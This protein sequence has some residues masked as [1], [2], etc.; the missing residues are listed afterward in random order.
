MIYNNGVHD[1]ITDPAFRAERQLILKQGEPMLFGENNDKGL[2]VLKGKLT[3][4]TPG[5]DDFTPGDILI[6]D[7]TE[8]D[9]LLHLALINM[10]FPAFPVAF[11]VIRSVP[12]PVYDQEMKNQIKRIQLN[13]SITC[14]DD[15]LKSGNTWEVKDNGSNN[16]KNTATGKK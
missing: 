9:P 4:V 2:A 12:A 1:V 13:R 10:R 3:V 14:M 8:P 15:L 5:K 16:G 6:H 7:A 11:G